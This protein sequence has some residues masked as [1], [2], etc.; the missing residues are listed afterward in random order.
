MLI[1]NKTGELVIIGG[2]QRYE[3]CKKLGIESVP[4]HIM[5]L[6]ED[7]EKE[8]IIRD[9]VNNGDWDIGILESAWIDCP[10][11]DWGVD[12]TFKLIDEEKEAKEDVIPEEPKAIYIQQG[13]VFRLG[14]H[15]L[16]CGDS[17]NEEQVAMLLFHGNRE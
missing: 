5:K 12:V 2:N 14:E 15:V 11:Q 7:E 1:S 6:T 3:A 17:M 4:V 16:V 9:N 13:D 8:I 10:L